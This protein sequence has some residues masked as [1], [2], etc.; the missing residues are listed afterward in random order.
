MLYPHKAKLHDWNKYCLRN[1]AFNTYSETG[2]GTRNL[3]TSGQTLG[4]PRIQSVCSDLMD[5]ILLT[6]AFTDGGIGLKRLA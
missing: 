2:N 1:G 3:S 4:H 5:Y 6:T